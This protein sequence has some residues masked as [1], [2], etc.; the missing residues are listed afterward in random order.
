MSA[1]DD[2]EKALAADEDLAAKFSEAL[3]DVKGAGAKSD[4]EAMVLAAKAAGF[5]V[6]PEDVEKELAGDQQLFPEDLEAI[7]GGGYDEYGND[8]LCIASWHCYTALRHTEAEDKDVAC[9]SDYL[10]TFA[11]NGC[12]SDYECLRVNVTKK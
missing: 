6:A 4:V 12:W 11:S 3:K 1:L 5:E 10:C 2:M 7:A 9:W 8:D